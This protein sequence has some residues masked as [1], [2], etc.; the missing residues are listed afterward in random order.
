MLKTQVAQMGIINKAT[1]IHDF[2]INMR[3]HSDT[4][5]PVKYNTLQAM[6]AKTG[7]CNNVYTT[8]FCIFSRYCGLVTGT[9]V[10][11]MKDLDMKHCYNTI[12]MDG[13]SAEILLIFEAIMRI[14]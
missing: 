5:D 6:S 1:Y 10:Y 7:V 9:V 4:S 14:I 11:D 12:I 13:G 2:L 3:E 8:L